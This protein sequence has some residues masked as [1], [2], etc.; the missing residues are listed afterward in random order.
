MIVRILIDNRSTDPD[1][2]AEWG[3]SI[4]I[5]YQ[6]RTY[7]LDTGAGEAFAQNADAMGVDLT[8]VSCGVL[9][10]AHYDHADG[11]E[12]FFTRNPDAPFWLR[13]GSRENCYD[14][15]DEFL[16]YIGIR[17]GTLDTWKDRIRY[18]EGKTELAP[19]VYLLGHT[20]PDLDACGQQHQMFQK[21]A[22]QFMYDDFRHE[23]SLIFDTDKGLILF[24]SC[25]HA[26]ADLVIQEALEAFPGKKVCAIVGGFHLFQTPADQVRAF[27]K[28]LEAT[29]VEHI[30][31]GHCTGQDAFE[32][33]RETLGDKVRQMETGLTLTF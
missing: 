15:K 1:L 9:S 12:T 29:G 17:P 8:Q 7:L 16:S 18:A 30:V 3:L 10:H 27:A 22:D 21:I 11:M 31:T 28:R 32:I 20:T 2:A 6:G 23:Q 14:C 24:N 5:E 26:G 13:M 4:H 19:G 33:L 25:C